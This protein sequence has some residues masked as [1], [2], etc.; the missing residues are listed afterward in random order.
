M[1]KHRP[2][3][4]HHE[5]QSVLAG[6]RRLKM[7]R[8]AHA[9]VRGST[10]KF[11]EWLEASGERGL[12]QGPHIWICGDCHLGNLGP[13]A[14]AEG[15]V[16]IHIRDLDQ[17]VIGNP[18]H[19]LIRLGLS[20]ATAARGSDLPGVT[21]AKML[22]EM[23][24][25]YLAALAGEP[26]ADAPATRP[27]A[28]RLIL[29]QAAG[30]RWRKLAKERLGR[31]R[32]RLPLGK[33][34]WRLHSAERDEIEALFATEAV[35]SMVTAL[36]SR[37]DDAPVEILDAAYWMKGC[38]SLGR[39]RYAVL[40]SVGGGD[41]SAGGQ[42]LIDIKEAI[43]PAAPRASGAVMPHGAPERVIA[44]AT[45]LSPHLGRR[46]RPGHLQ[47][48]GVVLRELMPQDLKL[49]LETLSQDE[50][51][52]A[53]H[54]LGSVVGLAHGRQMASGDKAAWGDELHRR[55]PKGLDAP[56]WL[57]SSVVDL[58]ATHEAAYLEHCR[59]YALEREAA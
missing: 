56:F 26:G 19:D 22:E 7:A 50:A 20:L 54:Y 6:E 25:G 5:R 33:R 17:T 43:G 14:S 11:Y 10:Q 13:V 23:M 47:G 41:G 48:R 34:F 46:M 29:R 51:M 58:V 55:W 9:Y 45:A 3:P 12:P 42:C 32:P 21:T 8:S 30:R 49:E 16:A 31:V 57:W 44:G 36:K 35:R 18:A 40:A 53:A 27:E 24:A 2:S 15:D 59:R 39:L 38:S 28:V 4:S 52:L 37:P 1:S